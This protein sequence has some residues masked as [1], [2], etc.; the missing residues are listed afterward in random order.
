MRKVA[1]V[2]SLEKLNTASDVSVPALECSVHQLV[3][4][5]KR[6]RPDFF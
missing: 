2:K 4:R 5:E 3:R 6:Y 1:F